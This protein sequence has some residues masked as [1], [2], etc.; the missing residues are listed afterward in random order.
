MAFL[1]ADENDISIKVVTFASKDKTEVIRRKEYGGTCIINSIDKVLNYIE[2]L[3]ETK[4]KIGSHKR[5]EEKLFD[6]ASFKEAWLNACIHTKWSKGNPP[7]VYIFSDRI[8]I[9]STG[10]LPIDLNKDEFYK[11]ISKPVNIKLQNIFGQLSYVEQTGHGIP[12]IISNY[13]KQA[14]DIMENFINVSI[15][16]N[17]H[18][19]DLIT[20]MRKIK[21]SLM[22]VSDVFLI[23][24]IKMRVLL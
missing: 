12:L 21:L 4:V 18:E 23:I 11:G 9:I 5:I 1:L 15:P 24:Y 19:H 3:N 20:L 16:F 17:F 14:F 2:A 10:G 22:R 6:I 8:E 7:A 13:G